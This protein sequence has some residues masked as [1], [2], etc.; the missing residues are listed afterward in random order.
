MEFGKWETERAH[1]EPSYPIPV[2]KPQNLHLPHNSQSKHN[3]EMKFFT[4]CNL[5]LHFWSIKYIF[6]DNSD[7][8]FL[9]FLFDSQYLFQ[10]YRFHTI[11]LI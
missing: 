9:L 10:S 6:F 8:Q 2:R 5:Y 3:S 7:F 1:S 4:I 11:Q